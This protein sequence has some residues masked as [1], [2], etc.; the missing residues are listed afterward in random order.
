MA[1]HEGAKEVVAWTNRVHVA[2]A[3]L[4]A[5]VHARVGVGAVYLHAVLS[6]FF[7]TCSTSLP[8]E[9][10]ALSGVSYRSAHSSVDSEGR[11]M[12]ASELIRAE[13]A[14]SPQTLCGS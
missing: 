4:A 5:C 12:S 1:V 10:T 2:C 8:D 3:R 14:T 9:D 7:R 6:K 11:A 13:E